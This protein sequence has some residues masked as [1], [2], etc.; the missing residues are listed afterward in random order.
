VILDRQGAERLSGKGDMLFFDGS[1]ETQRV[2]CAYAS[3][4]DVATMCRELNEEYADAQETLLP[5]PVR[6][7]PAPKKGKLSQV[8]I[9]TAKGLAGWYYFNPMLGGHMVYRSEL[10]LLQ[11]MGIVSRIKEPNGYRVLVNDIKEIN[12]I[13]A[14]YDS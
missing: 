11:E 9:L 5:E 13:L 1:P 8:T 2:Q 4:E 6:I 10:P 7:A 3:T 14:E 12:R